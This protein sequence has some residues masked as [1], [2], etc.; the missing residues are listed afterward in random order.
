MGRGD[1]GASRIRHELVQDLIEHHGKGAYTYAL[2]RIDQYEGDEMIVGMW[3]KVLEELDEH[4]KG[5]A[6]ESIGME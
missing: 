5:E 4:F 1:G 2:Q 3:R 6:N